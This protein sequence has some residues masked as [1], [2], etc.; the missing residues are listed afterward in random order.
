[1]LSATREGSVGEWATP[2]RDV[3]VF[4]SGD[5]PFSSLTHLTSRIYAKLIARHNQRPQSPWSHRALRYH[6]NDGDW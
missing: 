4:G 2:G 5:C 3:D 6:P 1:M